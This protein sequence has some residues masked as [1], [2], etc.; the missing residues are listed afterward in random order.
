M[1][2]STVTLNL[3]SAQTARVVAA[4]DAYNAANGTT[5]TNKQ[6]V[7]QAIRNAVQS[8]VISSQAAATM[9]TLAGQV[10]VDM[11]PAA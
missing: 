1:P 5:L 9:Q 6:Y 4:K 11:E 3:T 10:A 8:D 2:A 7:M